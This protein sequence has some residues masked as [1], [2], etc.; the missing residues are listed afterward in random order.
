MKLLRYRKNGS[1]KPG[2]LDDEGNIR[3]ASSIV[4]DWTGDTVNISNF[5]KLKEINTNDLPI[6]CECGGLEKIDKHFN[7]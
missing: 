5:S 1:V 7:N 2:I 4:N 3:E 6:V